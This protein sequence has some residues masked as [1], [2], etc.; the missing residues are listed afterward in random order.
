MDAATTSTG[1]TIVVSITDLDYSVSSNT[2]YATGTDAGTN[3]PVVYYKS[4]S[5]SGKWTP[6]G[7]S[8]LPSTAGKIGKA[9][10]YGI[11]TVYCA[12]DN[13]VYY[14]PTSGSSWT[15][16]Y[17]YPVGTKINFLYYDDLLVATDTGL[18][19]QAGPSTATAGI[20]DVETSNFLKMYPNPVVSNETMTVNY[21]LGFDGDLFIS[22]FNLQGK[23]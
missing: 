16:G 10:T 5:G 9:I 15:K 22:I 1:T 8:G 6:Y 4:L 2:V 14:Y 12:V 21:S 7:S 17:T 11:D 19:A 18:Y 20:D 23:I 3:N 13:E